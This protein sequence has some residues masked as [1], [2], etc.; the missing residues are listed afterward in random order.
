MHVIQR[1]KQKYQVCESASKLVIEVHALGSLHCSSKDPL[2][3]CEEAQE[4][5]SFSS[6]I[7]I[8]TRKFS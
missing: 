4:P 1:N 5:N 2:T 6:G 3:P 7:T 8:A